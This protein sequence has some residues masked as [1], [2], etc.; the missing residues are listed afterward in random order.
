MLASPAGY[1]SNSLADG[2]A[3]AMGPC[4]TTR[5]RKS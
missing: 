1:I 3:S 2:T 4:M 5:S